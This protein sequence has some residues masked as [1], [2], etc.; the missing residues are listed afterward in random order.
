MTKVVSIYEAKTQLSK[1]IKEAQA[2]KTIYIGA[3]G[4]PQAILGPAPARKPLMIGI[5]THKKKD[6]AYKLDDLVAP[7]PEINAEFEESLN[8]PLS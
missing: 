5:W 2:G 4:H 6:N 3:Y 7:D 1:L 8:K